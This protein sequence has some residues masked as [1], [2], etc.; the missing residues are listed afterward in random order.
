[1]LHLTKLCVYLCLSGLLSVGAVACRTPS[2]NQTASPAPSVSAEPKKDPTAKALLGEW[3]VS[4]K[5]Q[6]ESVIPSIFFSSNGKGYFV[7]QLD[8]K[9]QATEF[10][11]TLKSDAKPMQL[12]I[13][14]P[15]EAQ[16]IQTIFALSGDTLRLETQTQPGVPRPTNFSSQTLQLKRVSNLTEL[17]ADVF[18]IDAS[19]VPNRA[20]L[21][22]E[23]EVKANIGTLNRAQQTYFLENT[24]FAENLELLGVAIAPESESYRYQIAQAT[25][26]QVVVNAQAKNP[27]LK[28]FVG[29]V[30]AEKTPTVT[31]STTL[32]FICETEQ[33]TQTP[34]AIGTVYQASEFQCPQGSRKVK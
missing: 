33:A 34:P 8:G 16:P 21:A 26:K 28:S 24:K 7:N 13:L 11:Y 6:R 32:T 9:K 12:D 31:G 23:S 27:E 4:P 20:V 19:Q 29:V 3:H 22:K 18:L 25:D 17:P 5:K 2:M 30:I 15:G 10:Q 14:L 1:M